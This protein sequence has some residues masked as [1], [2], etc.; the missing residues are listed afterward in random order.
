MDVNHTARTER[1]VEQTEPLQYIDQNGNPY[2]EIPSRTT[3]DLGATYQLAE[4][5]SLRANV[6]NAFEW[7][8][9]PV[10][11]SIG[12]FTYGRTYNLGLTYQF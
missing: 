7:E 1:N 6:L 10:E 5:L 11:I 9:S 3:F 2:T 8:P 12:R 4:G